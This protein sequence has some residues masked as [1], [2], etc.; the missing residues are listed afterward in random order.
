MRKLRGRLMPPPGNDRPTEATID[1]F[2]GN[3]EAY[4]DSV[5]AAGA[6]NPGHIAVHRLNR[7]E[8]ANALEDILAVKVDAEELLPPDTSSDGFDNV[9]EVLQVSPSFLEQ[10]LSAAR[11]VSIL[12]VSEAPPAPEVESFE[13]PSLANQYRHV[14]GLPM[15]TR[16]GFAAEH[17]FPAAG[18]YEF[19]IEIASQEGSLQ[20]S[21]P[22][23]WLES[24]HQF[25]LT[26]DGEEVYT[27]S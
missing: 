3:M 21:Y 12:A 10:Y 7:K 8:Y 24:K 16:G 1:D 6:S 25:I 9:A 19:N 4:L 20:R 5:A 17:Y 11:T 23:W 22:T 27:T 18:E 15:G 13:A 14:D 2:V 26:I